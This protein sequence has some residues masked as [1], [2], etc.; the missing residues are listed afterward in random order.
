MPHLGTSWD[1]LGAVAHQPLSRLSSRQQELA[2][3]LKGLGITADRMTANEIQE[4]LGCDALG[5]GSDDF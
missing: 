4:T 3:E 1:I 5:L 2:S